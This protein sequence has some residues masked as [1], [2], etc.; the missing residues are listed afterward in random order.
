MLYLR[1]VSNAF[2]PL[3]N[4]LM[5]NLSVV[6]SQILNNLTK[7]KMNE[8]AASTVL[9]N[10]SIVV[11][12]P[13]LSDWATVETQTEVLMAAGSML[14]VLEDGEAIFRTLVAVGNLASGNPTMGTLYKSLGGD[15]VLDKFVKPGS[16]TKV[17]QCALQIKN[18]L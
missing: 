1:L 5:K 7:A 13:N 11:R 4:E 10:Y 6:I 2:G 3:T 8:V 16:V 17:Q 14:E 12:D 18:C 9:L 15:T